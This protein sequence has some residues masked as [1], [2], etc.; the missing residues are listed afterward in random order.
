MFNILTYLEKSAAQY[1]DKIAFADKDKSITYEE[2]VKRSKGIG[3]QLAKQFSPRTPI[4]VFMEKSVDTIS[5]FF[6]IVYAGCFYVLLDTKQPKTRLDH[7]LNTLNVNTLITSM[8]YDRDLKKIEFAGKVIYLEELEEDN[9]IN[10]NS[11]MKIKE[12]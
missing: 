7:I 4:P 12:H 1:P 10:E 8:G 11:L 6:G 5:L 9:V 2:L 3:S